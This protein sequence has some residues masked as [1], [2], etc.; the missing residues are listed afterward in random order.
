MKRE[1]IKTIAY[2]VTTVFGPASFV[3]GGIIGLT[4]DPENL[5]TLAEMVADDQGTGST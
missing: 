3:I 2:W 5:K 4:R 1:R